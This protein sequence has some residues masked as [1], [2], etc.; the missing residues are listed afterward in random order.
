MRVLWV[1][2]RILPMFCKELGIKET[3]FGGG[4]LTGLSESLRKTDGIKL[5]VCMPYSKIE[6]ILHGA[7]KGVEYYLYHEQGWNCYRDENKVLLKRVTDKFQPDVVHVFGTEYPRTLEVLDAIGSERVLISLTGILTECYPV[8]EAKIPAKY[9]KEH[10][11]LR[12]IASRHRKLFFLQNRLTAY[13]KSDFNRRMQYEIAALKKARFVTGRTT[14]D[15]EVVKRLNPNIQYFFCNESLRSVFY[16]E[17]TWQYDNCD[18][19][20]IFVSNAGY[21]IKGFHKLLEAAPNLLKKY[22]DLKIR[23]AG[24]SPFAQTRGIKNK[25][26]CITDE[27]GKYIRRLIKKNGLMSAVE[28]LGNLDAQRMKNEFLRA[29]V[30]LLPSVIENSPNSLGEAMILKVP[31]I[32]SDVGGVSDMMRNGVEGFTYDFNDVEGLTKAID[33]LFNDPKLA[34]KLGEAASQHAVK[35]HCLVDNNET[36]MQIYRE[37]ANINRKEREPYGAV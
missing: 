1:I 11:L 33:C 2:N 9:T 24:N 13:G 7:V 10:K 26:L 25:I 12:F 31:C 20:T 15:Y 4:W 16:K 6:G 37:I 8:Y 29:N 36:M 30:F 34:T 21:P 35:T 19:H 17:P 23:V 22:P 28:F 5:A 18:K 14:F 3:N 32:A 27:Y